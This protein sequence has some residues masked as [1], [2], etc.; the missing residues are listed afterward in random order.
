M[1]ETKS[2]PQPESEF[3]RRVATWVIVLLAVYLAYSATHFWGRPDA[4]ADFFAMLARRLPVMVAQILPPAVFAGALSGCGI[5]GGGPAGSPRR[6]WVLLA[7][8]AMAAY[9]LPSLVTP[10][11]AKWTGSDWP[12]PTAVLE[13]ARSARAA[14]EAAI[15][16]EAARHLRRAAS[17]LATLFVPMANAAFVLLA[18]VL[19]DLTGR[20]TRRLSTWPRYATRWLSGGLLFAT[21]WIPAAVADELVRYDAVWGGLLFVLPIC[22]PLAAAGILFAVV[23]PDR[24]SAR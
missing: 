19:G 24:G 21:F 18:A 23:R 3:A 4:V 15:R 13:S 22:V 6:H 17:A 20:S 7:M 9:A 1:I 14:A 2:R 16:N 10:V 5:F 12:F 8:L 11:F